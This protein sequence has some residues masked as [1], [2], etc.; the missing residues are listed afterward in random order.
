VTAASS[1]R[2]RAEPLCSDDHVCAP[3]ASGAHACAEIFATDCARGRHIA[4]CGCE[5][6]TDAYNAAFWARED[7][8][9]QER[10]AAEWEGRMDP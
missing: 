5:P 3:C 7:A 4:S 2:S 10:W 1:D 9:E 6:C 8:R